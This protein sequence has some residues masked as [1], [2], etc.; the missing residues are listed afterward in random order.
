MNF[1]GE[2]IQITGVQLT[3]GDVS[4]VPNNTST[5]LLVI[6]NAMSQQIGFSNVVTQQ[7]TSR[8]TPIND[9]I[10]RLPITYRIEGLL[11]ASTV[12]NTLDVGNILNFT[13]YMSSSFSNIKQAALNT[14]L[15]TVSTGFSV[16]EGYALLSCDVRQDKE[17]FNAL[18]IEL[19]MQEAMKSPATVSQTQSNSNREPANRGKLN[20]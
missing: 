18:R 10:Y 5:F 13:N 16:L 11:S 12:T 4:N 20:A 6:D 8:G 7:P 17:A 2:T 9:N 19:V 14:Y 3:I 1:T 15:F